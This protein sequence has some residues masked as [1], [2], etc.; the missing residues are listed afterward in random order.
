MA[1][2]L[3]KSLILKKCCCSLVYVPEEEDHAPKEFKILE[4]HNPYK[5]IHSDCDKAFRKQ[6]L[7]DYHI[8]YYHTE[9][10]RVIQP[11]PSR[12]RRKTIS[13]CE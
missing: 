8:K 7:L 12:Q 3:H 2:I 5:C 6:S 1:L 10:G 4:D 11:P 9:D 13:I